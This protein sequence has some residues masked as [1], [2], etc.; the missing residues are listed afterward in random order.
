[1][2]SISKGKIDEEKL[3][4]AKKTIISS[5]KASLDNPIGIISNYY[6]KELVNSLDTEERIKMVSEVSSEDII[7]VSKKISMHTVFVLEAT[8]EKDND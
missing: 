3:E 7:K 8:D 2:K 5:I 1:M 6:A 4:D